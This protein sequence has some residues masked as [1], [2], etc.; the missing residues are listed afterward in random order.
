MF[1]EE[2]IA[3]FQRSKSEDLLDGITIQSI[4]NLLQ[5]ASMAKLYFQLEGDD[6]VIKEEQELKEHTTTYHQNL[7]GPTETNGF[8]M[9]EDSP[10]V[11]V[12]ENDFF[13]N[14]FTEN[15]VKVA[16]FQMERDKTTRTRLFSDRNLSSVL[17]G[18][19]SLFDGNVL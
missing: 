15:E 13:A 2:D 18:H 10:Q 9:L 3:L 11:S 7:L 17:G 5:M 12:L 4:S 6:R 19:K 16:I 1:R 8:K 14:M